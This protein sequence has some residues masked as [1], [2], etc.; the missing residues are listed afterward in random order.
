MISGLAAANNSWGPLWSGLSGAAGV[1][2]KKELIGPEPPPESSVMYSLEQLRNLHNKFIDGVFYRGT[3]EI[4]LFRDGKVES[5][6]LAGTTEIDKVF[7]KRDTKIKY[8][9]GGK[10]ERGTL[11]LT[12]KIDRAVYQQDTEIVFY[13]DGRVKEG[14]LG[15]KMDW[16]GDTYPA[17][18]RVYYD[19]LGRLERAIIRQ[20]DQ[21][22]KGRS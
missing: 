19:Q 22:M 7:Y 2:Q 4:K 21:E 20:I 9:P 14:T 3:E 17:G 10:V 6:T 15:K 11:A 13:P 16:R 1:K 18:T 5:A 12:D 8:Y